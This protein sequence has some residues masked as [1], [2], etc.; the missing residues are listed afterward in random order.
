M[1]A[2]IRQQMKIRFHAGAVSV[3]VGA[4]VCVVVGVAVGSAPRPAASIVKAPATRTAGLNAE[5][6]IKSRK[7]SRTACR[8]DAM[9][10]RPCGRIVTYT[11]LAPGRH[12][13]RVRVRHAGR[14]RFVTRRWTIVTPAVRI[15]K[16]PAL[17]TRSRQAAF[18]FKTKAR[19]ASCRI[20]V[21]R[22]RRCFTTVRYKHLSAGRHRFLVRVRHKGRTTY[23]SREWTIV[24][25]S[26]SDPG[27][28]LASPTF[29]TPGSAVASTTGTGP[30]A[31]R[32][33]IFSD[34]F[35]GTAL[36]LNRW[37]PYSSAGHDGNGLRRP[38][39][40]SLDGQGNLVMTA[41]MLNGQIVS[42]GMSNRGLDFMYGRVEFRVKAEPDPTGTMSAV[43]LTWPKHQWAPEF[44]ENDMYETGPHA[45]N[46]SHFESFIHFGAAN[47]QHWK[48][49]E[50]DPSQWRTIAMEWYPNLLEIYVDGQ[51]GLSISDP[52]VIP[53]NLHHLAIQ[54]D[55]RAQR[56]LSRPVRMYV[57]YVRVYQ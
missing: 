41:S 20:D 18:K 15:V 46:R 52:A 32:R 4:V 40:I 49:H 26:T 8:R 36:D 53:D 23:A 38:S 5:F 28:P 22:Y 34:E 1:Y 39:A 25:A 31:Q 37:S 11:G 3:C 54:L 12:V 7:G 13:F 57:D 10:Y 56:T 2:S 51:L 21:E 29:S 33:L 44:T 55:A 14:T 24:G 16:A 50:V 17:R 43:V 45:N 48:R 9:R 42:G 35:D 27:N 19:R 47:W 30:S 6:H